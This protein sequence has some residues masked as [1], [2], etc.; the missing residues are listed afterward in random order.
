MVKVDHACFRFRGAFFSIAFLRLAQGNIGRLWCVKSHDCIIVLKRIVWCILKASIKTG[1]LKTMVSLVFTLLSCK[2]HYIC[3][4]LLSPTHHGTLP[5]NAI[6]MHG[7][8][9]ELP[10]TFHIT[11]ELEILLCCVALTVSRNKVSHW[12]NHVEIMDLVNSVGST[13]GGMWS[14]SNRVLM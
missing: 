8:W 12:L 10:L 14:S 2:Y 13:Y 6:V 5:I 1:A 7:L 9:C 3:F 11:F 4:W